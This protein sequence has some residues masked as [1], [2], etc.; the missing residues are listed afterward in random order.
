[1][2]LCYIQ[3]N[4]TKQPVLPQEKVQASTLTLSEPEAPEDIVTNRV[5]SFMMELQLSIDALNK[6]PA[7]AAELDKQA[8]EK[9]VN[10]VLT[11]ED[12]KV[13]GMLNHFRTK[14][15]LEGL[16]KVLTIT[17]RYFC[18]VQTASCWIST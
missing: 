16:A 18:C 17:M 6:S 7:D 13:R 9:A 15:G 2:A 12:S 11:K 5:D 4:P 14:L 1:V 10:R 3:E 8:V